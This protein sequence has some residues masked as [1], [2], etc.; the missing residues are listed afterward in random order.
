MQPYKAIIFDIGGVCVGSPFQG[1]AKYERLCNLPKNYINVAIEK[2]G[3]CGAFQ[4]LERG[5][6]SIP[7]FYKIF[8]SELSDP[9]NKEYYLQYLRSR[10]NS[11]VPSLPDIIT[12]DGKELFRTMMSETAKIDPIVFNAIKKLRAKKL[13]TAAL[14]NNFQLPI[15]DQEEIEILG[16]SPPTDF[17][18]LFDEYIESSVIGL[19]KP[20]PKIF[21]YACEKLGVKPNEVIFL[22]DIGMNLKAARDLGMKTIKVNLGK[23]VDAIKELENLIG[24]PLL[25]NSKS[26]SAKL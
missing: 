5:E 4:R 26:N 2:S 14:T 6:L 10:R 21:L 12:I 20:D 1:V 19:R 22:D 15:Q 11:N 25:E 16:G 9:I 24:I 18:K 17:K 13:K 7:E 8:G 23:S 3:E